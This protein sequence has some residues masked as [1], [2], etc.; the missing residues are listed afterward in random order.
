MEL[1]TLEK[2]KAYGFVLPEVGERDQV[3]HDAL[4]GY[5]ANLRSGTR[6]TKTKATVKASGK[7]PWR[8]K[9]TGRARAGYVS[10]P[11]WVGGG[12]VFGPQPRDFSKKLP[13]KVKNLAFLKA[14]AAKITSEELYC[15]DKVELDE[16]K[17]KKIFSLLEGWDGRESCL[18]VLKLPHRNVLLS[19]RNIPHLAIVRAQDVNA[20]DLL[21][22][23]KVY[24]EKEALDVFVERAKKLISKNTQNDEGEAVR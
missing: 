2:A 8:Q 4:S 18:L 23:K 22:Y 12:V 21:S 13:K 20:L 1:M 24:I 19:G 9:G 15:L 17:T 10:S 3:L 11:L 14:F 6:A 7:K 16:I 5:L